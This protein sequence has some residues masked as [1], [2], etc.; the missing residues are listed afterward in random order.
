MKP[1]LLVIVFAIVALHFSACTDA[2]TPAS[3]LPTSGTPLAINANYSGEWRGGWRVM[4][5]TDL[6]PRLGYCRSN[7]SPDFE[8]IRL[9]L[10]QSGESVTGRMQARIG[11]GPVTGGVDLLGRLRLEGTLPTVPGRFPVTQITDWRTVINPDDGTLVGGF[12]IQHL[13]STDLS[14]AAMTVNEMAIPRCACPGT[15]GVFWEC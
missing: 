2:P 7:V 5:C 3:Q 10:A 11:D 4:S 12:K 14:P 13:W 6:P 15:T 1:A 8:P 9:T